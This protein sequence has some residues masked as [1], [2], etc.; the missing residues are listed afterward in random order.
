M[1]KD[2]NLFLIDPELKILKEINSYKVAN[3][4]NEDSNKKFSSLS[5]AYETIK[6]W[7]NSCR[8]Y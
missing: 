2:Y 3:Q 7:R 8:T 1:R 6:T 4:V 5:Y